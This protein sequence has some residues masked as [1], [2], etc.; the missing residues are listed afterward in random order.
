MSEALTFADVWSHSDLLRHELF[1]DNPASGSS[2]DVMWWS[3]IEV[4]AV[5]QTAP[6]L[7]A[8]S[9]LLQLRLSLSF[10]RF[11]LPTCCDIMHIFARGFSI[12]SFKIQQRIKCRYFI[13][14][15]IFSYFPRRTIRPSHWIC[16][17][18]FNA[19][20]LMAGFLIGNS[21]AIAVSLSHVLCQIE[22]ELNW[23][24]FLLT[25]IHQHSTGN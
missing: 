7:P 12:S 11:I 24:S 3:M 18:F 19:G 5:F 4:V 15:I 2:C 20:Q 17:E 25:A 13:V 16:R 6:G 10:I 23:I 14:P 21:W 1:R 22:L 8:L 9:L